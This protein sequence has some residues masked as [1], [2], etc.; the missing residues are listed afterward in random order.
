LDHRI[1]YLHLKYLPE[2][3]ADLRRFGSRVATDLYKLHLEAERNPPR[4]ENFDAW[5]NR[6]D[7]L[8]TCQE[9]KELKKVSATEGLISIPYERKFSIYSRLYQTLKLY[10]FSPS[11]GLYSCPLAMTDGA[12][13]TI[14][15]YFRF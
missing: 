11:S 12:A 14:E 15:V 8:L 1:Y 2:I 5:G 3:E 13:R 6:V 7:K 9:W 10:L 4:L